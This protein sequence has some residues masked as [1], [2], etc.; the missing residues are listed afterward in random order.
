MSVVREGFRQSKSAHDLERN[1]IDDPGIAR[2]AAFVGGPSL[3]AIGGRWVDQL[4]VV[5]QFF[6]QIGVTRVERFEMQNIGGLNF[7]AKGILRRG[8]RNDAQGKALAQ[9][10]LSMPMNE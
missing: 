8:L 3:F 6:A 1:Q 4:P 2:F 5:Q 10:L 9:A 7:V